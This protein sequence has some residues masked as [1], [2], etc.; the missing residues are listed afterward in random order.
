[1]KNGEGVLLHGYRQLKYAKLLRI[2]NHGENQSAKKKIDENNGLLL[3]ANLDKE[4]D[5]MA[6]NF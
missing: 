1:M 6:N 4:F 2:S 5:Q 3:V